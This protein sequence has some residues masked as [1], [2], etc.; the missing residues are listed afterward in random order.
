[1]NRE[2]ESRPP[3]A[4]PASPPTRGADVATAVDDVL[5]AAA[6]G[7]AQAT[8]QLLPLVYE[9]LR[10]MARAKLSAEPAGQTI[11]PT[12]LVHEAYLK[13]VRAE[14]PWSSRQ[15]FFAAAA[16]AMRRILVDRARAKRGEKRGGKAGHFSLEQWDAPAASGGGPGGPDGGEGEFDWLALEEAMNGLERH[17]RELAQIVHLR[18]FAG[19]SLEET[20]LAVGRSTRTVNRDWNV[21]RAWLLRRMSGG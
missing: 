3:S 1:M 17:D 14:R 7:D 8:E 18:Y 5:D 13:L 15:H 2:P 11:Q 10:E 16:L 9:H 19:L 6:R 12:A 21:A 4:P 20:A